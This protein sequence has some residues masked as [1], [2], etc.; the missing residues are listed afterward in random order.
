MVELPASDP[1]QRVADLG[2]LIEPSHRARFEGAPWDYEVRVAL[3]ASY[4]PTGERR[5]P[6]LWVTDGSMLF[7]TA[8]SEASYARAFG[9]PEMIIVSVGTAPEA[10]VPG[11]FL[12]RRTFDFSPTPVSEERRK[13][14]GSSEAF[15]TGGAPKFLAFLI[16]DLRPQ[17]AARYRVLNDHTLYGYSYGGAFGGY[18]LFSRPSGFDRYICASGGWNLNDGE[19]FQIEAEYASKHT[20]LKTKL[21]L[22][23]GDGEITEERMSAIGIASGTTRMAET[24]AE[25]RYPSLEMTVRVFPGL[26]HDG[27]GVAT[28]LF[29]GLRAVWPSSAAGN[30]GPEFAHR[31]H[32]ALGRR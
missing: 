10:T 20:D 14:T 17:I 24:L 6:V 4:D 30:T 5:Y 3:P 27:K 15:P 18:A 22:S 19:L 16:D 11:E 1:V 21:F 32:P 7:E 2:M 8:V 26:R 28:S 23:V 9:V 13:V 25:R 12:P 31:V 29:E